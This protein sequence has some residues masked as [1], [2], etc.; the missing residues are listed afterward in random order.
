MSEQKPT[1]AKGDKLYFWGGKPNSPVIV[2]TVVNSGWTVNTGDEF[3]H[4]IDGDGNFCSH[5]PKEDSRIYR[6][7]TD[8]PA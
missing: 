3:V 6:R 8:I 4:W 1:F 5:F 7:R 2:G